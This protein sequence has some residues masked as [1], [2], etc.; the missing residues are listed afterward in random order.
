M[1]S[2]WFTFENGFQCIQRI[3]ERKFSKPFPIFGE[4]LSVVHRWHIQLIT[5]LIKYPYAH[6]ILYIHIS[7]HTQ[8]LQ[9]AC[10]C[11]PF[12]IY[13]YLFIKS[14]YVSPTMVPNVCLLFRQHSGPRLGYQSNI[15]GSSQPQS[16]M[17][18]SSSSHQ[19][20]QYSHQ[21]HRY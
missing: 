1:C 7:R 16:T 11:F 2:H 5:G 8:D 17:G 20:S 18:Y 3:F 15:Q 19:S 13:F 14:C 6:N 10:C 9:G 4:R 12:G 21:T